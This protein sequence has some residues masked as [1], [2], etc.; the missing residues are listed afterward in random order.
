MEGI[1][2]I[3]FDGSKQEM[4]DMRCP[5]CG[6]FIGYSITD[7]N[8]TIWCTSCKTKESLYKIFEK[9]NCQAFYGNKHT[10]G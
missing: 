7:N 9:P 2:E 5:E 10:F 3:L 1:D 8:M 6:G 4:E